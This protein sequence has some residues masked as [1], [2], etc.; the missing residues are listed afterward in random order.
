MR[1][2]LRIGVVVASVVFG[3]MMPA[4]AHQT[5][6]GVDGRNPG[7]AFDLRRVWVD[8]NA[9]RVTGWIQTHD[10][11]TNS[12]LKRRGALAFHLWKRGTTDTRGF[13][14]V[15]ITRNW[16]GFR[17]KLFRIR[18]NGNTYRVGSGSAWRT[19]PNEIGFSFRRSAVGMGGTTTIRWTTLSIYCRTNS[20]DRTRDDWLPN[21]GSEWHHLP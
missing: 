15:F 1:G 13:Y 16:Y 5:A 14:R 18:A 7:T 17:V 10:G 19:A 8:H 21:Y 2:G 4:G 9:N 20:C 11:F 12:M 6:S 3:L